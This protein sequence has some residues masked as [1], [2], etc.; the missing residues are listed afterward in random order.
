MP[1]EGGTAPLPLQ[2]REL[3]ASFLFDQTR[4]RGDWRPI[5]SPLSFESESRLMRK[6][7]ER[8]SPDPSF[9][10]A[11]QT[12]NRSVVNSLPFL[13]S[14][15]FRLTSTRHP[16]ARASDCSALSHVRPHTLICRSG[17]PRLG[18][19]WSDGCRSGPS[20]VC[21][22]PRR[23]ESERDGAVRPNGQ[24]ARRLPGPERGR[25]QREPSAGTIPVRLPPA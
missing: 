21:E 20:S 11:H 23:G 15:P 19:S 7:R 10:P 14:D 25:A 12:V 3:R 18:C 6:K 16:Q 9:L 22:R 4:D 2:T 8:S 17:D 13:F 24:A 5:A 1:Y